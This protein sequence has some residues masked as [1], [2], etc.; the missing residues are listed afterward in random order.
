MQASCARHG[1]DRSLLTA[2]ALEVPRG[3]HEAQRLNR[4]RK[5]SQRRHTFEVMAAVV[6]TE[7]NVYV[8]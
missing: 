2:Q 5:A 1:Y 4:A 8:T 3:P 6:S 7:A